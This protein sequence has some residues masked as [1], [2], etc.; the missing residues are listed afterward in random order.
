MCSL[1]ALPVPEHRPRAQIGVYPLTPCLS[2][3]L[4]CRWW[5]KVG[6]VGRLLAHYRAGGRLPLPES[7]PAPLV[8]MVEA[9]W[10]QRPEERPSFAGLAAELDK[11]G[12][13][14]Q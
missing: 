8:S 14:L 11:G 12:P 9:C 1:L 4:P 10:S 2:A 5:H 7:V 13:G 6:F 3:L